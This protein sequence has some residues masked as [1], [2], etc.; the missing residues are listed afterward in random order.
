MGNQADKKFTWVIKKFSSFAYRSE[1]YSDIFVAGGCKWRLLAFPK[2]NNSD[3]MCSYFSLYLF[4]PNS[5]SLPSGWSRHAKFSFTMVNQIPEGLSQLREA[6]YWFDQENTI[7]GFQYMFR[8][9]E[10]KGSDKGLLV[11]GEVKIV[12]EVDVLEVIGTL[13]VPP[14]KPKSID[15]NGFQ[16]PSSQV[17]S[18]YSLVNAYSTL[19]FVRKARINYDWLEKKLKETGK[20]RLQEIEQELKDL[21]VKCADMEALLEFLR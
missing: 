14:E 8:L 1:I 21:R 3:F 13:D 10:F 7:M 4:V 19:R 5:E 16:V 12:A 20:T 11:N 9:A 15:I 2:G 17:E 18:V 6:E